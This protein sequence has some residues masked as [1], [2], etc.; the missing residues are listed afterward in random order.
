[1]RYRTIATVAAAVLCCSAPAA[2]QVL[3]PTFQ[4]PTSSNDIGIYVVDVGD[5]G[6]E[7]V[8]RRSLGAGDLGLRAGFADVNDGNVLLLGVDYRNPLQLSGTAPLAIAFTVGAQAALLDAEVF[9]V[10]G[11]LSVGYAFDSPDLRL[12]PYIHPR[13]A[14]VSSDDD[15]ELEVLAD[16][17]LDVGITPTLD[18][19]FGANLGDGADWGLG[20]AFRR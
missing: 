19:R 15:T 8:L 18:L 3:T 17:G 2:A 16:V 14:L 7:G 5:L 13:L 20:L 10:Q 12:T 6:V 9:G 1:M 4:A 11:G